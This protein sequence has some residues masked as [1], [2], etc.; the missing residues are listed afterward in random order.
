M[1]QQPVVAVGQ[2]LP[3]IL[4][5]Q[6]QSE[7]HRA[8]LIDRGTAVTYSALDEES[9]RVARAL[10]E[11]GVKSGDRVAVW[12]PNV[13]A[14]LTCFFACVRLGAIVVALNT[15]FR[16][17]EIADVIKRSGAKVLIFWPKFK[18]VDLQRILA[19][20]DP[21]S[22]ALLE[23]IIVYDEGEPA[24][25][26][27]VA[28]IAPTKRVHNYGNLVKATALEV[29]F[30]APELGCVIF[31]TSGTTRAPKFVLHNQSAL[32]RHARDVASSFGLQTPESTILVNVPFAGIFGFCQ[33]T[34]AL[35]AGAAMATS[36]IFS[37]QESMRSIASHHITHIVASD[38]MIDRFLASA[39]GPH[40]FA[41]VK[42]C[43]YAVFTPGLED[44]GSRA[45]ARGLKLV[46]VYGSSEV[47]AL[48]ARQS[49]TASLEERVEKGGRPMAAEAHVRVR[50]TETGRLLAHREE[51]ELEIKGPSRMMGYFEDPGASADAIT[52]DGYFRTGDLGY[53]L[54]DGRFVYLARLGDTLRLGGFLVSPAEIEAVVQEHPSVKECQIVGVEAG[55]DWRAFAFVIVEP[56]PLIEE[57]EIINYCVRRLAKS[58]VPVRVQQIDAFPVTEGANATKI[59]KGKLRKL[60]QETLGEIP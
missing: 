31:T 29:D 59:Q 37:A 35:V 10:L 18:E 9:R 13:P 8:F 17:S 46:G 58:K 57:T 40:P 56:G 36:P 21:E 22:L 48:F 27:D 26:A 4:T 42:F 52:D 47:Q 55:H 25:I 39:D 24:R 43:A 23:T 53:T 49:E 5:Q 14:W 60:A 7:P 30:G 28:D 15:R 1:A 33:A 16:S 38:A 6:A 34:A 54:P 12:L 20:V 11:L 50:D 41:S 32:L 44:I 45:E 2:T 19:D 3:G 51:G